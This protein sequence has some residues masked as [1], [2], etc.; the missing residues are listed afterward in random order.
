M[1]RSP[2]GVF[3]WLLPVYLRRM[4]LGSPAPSPPPPLAPP[5]SGIV[6]HLENPW[7][8]ARDSLQLGDTS[9]TRFAHGSRRHVRSCLRRRS[10]STTWSPTR[11][12]SFRPLVRLWH[13]PRIHRGERGAHP[14]G[15]QIRRSAR[16]QRVLDCLGPARQAA[17]RRPAGNRSGRASRRRRPS[18]AGSGS[19]KMLAGEVR[20]VS[21]VAQGDSSLSRTA[22]G[23]RGGLPNGWQ[24]DLRGD[25]AAV[26]APAGCR[27]VRDRRK[28]RGT[29]PG[30]RHVAARPSQLDDPP[31]YL[32][33]A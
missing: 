18:R 26:S 17:R 11:T 22:V 25:Y 15:G 3:A 21:D 32:E 29:R 12:G 8:R 27:Y 31:A 5:I 2:L 13:Q 6:S 10:E 4:V 28:R 1:R 24:Y 16:P 23:V 19:D 7:R 30:C 9:L 14:A 20:T 33:P